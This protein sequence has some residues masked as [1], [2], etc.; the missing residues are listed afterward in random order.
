MPIYLCPLECS[1]RLPK[2]PAMASLSHRQGWSLAVLLAIFPCF[3]F[4]G[5]NS[6]S[7]STAPSPTYRT[8]TNEVRVAFFATDGENRRVESVVQNDFAVVDGDMVI[9]DF[10][11]LIRSEETA[12]D[13]VIL[14]DASESV[15]SHFETV[16]R[17]VARL[18]SQ[19]RTGD[20]LAVVAFSGLKSNMLCADDCASAEMIQKLRDLNAA[21]A[22][23]LFD[24]MKKMARYFEGRRNP[25][26]RQVMILFSDG[27]DTIS[28]SCAHDALIAITSTGA[29]LYG[30]DLEERGSK[31]SLAL[32]EIAE[33]TGGRSLSKQ[34]SAG[35]ILQ[36][37]LADLHAS[38]VVTYALPSRAV[39]F[40]SLRILPKHN[41]N[42]RFHCRR[43]YFYDQDR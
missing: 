13:V 31:N 12:L 30:V 37:I 10:R 18:I 25:A 38:Y 40:H 6:G 14:V 23:P 3:L 4:A 32:Q 15:A 43:G 1:P 16:K 26:V 19:S 42:L 21:G 33:A 39:G 41:L 29:L 11:S 35:D 9:R 27:N 22:T 2:Y 28:A 34:E 20:R 36:T 7:D 24:S 17:E 8:G 5:S